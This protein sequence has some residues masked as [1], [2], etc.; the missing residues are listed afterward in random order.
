MVAKHLVNPIIMNIFILS[1][2]YSMVTMLTPYVE[3]LKTLK[4]R[5]ELRGASQIY[6]IE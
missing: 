2:Q 6:I 3:G 5:N 1:I 4:H